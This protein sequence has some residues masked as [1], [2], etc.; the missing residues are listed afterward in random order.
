MSKW[1]IFAAVTFYFQTVSISSPA[2]AENRFIEVAVVSYKDSNVVSALQVAKQFVKDQDILPSLW[3]FN[4]TFLTPS[5]KDP[6]NILT[7]SILEGHFDLI[8]GPSLHCEENQ[9]PS[10][11]AIQDFLYFSLLNIEDSFRFPNLIKMSPL[12]RHHAEAIVSILQYCKY[13]RIAIITSEDKQ[14]LWKEIQWKAYSV[15]IDE[16]SLFPIQSETELTS[17][18]KDVKKQHLNNVVVLDTTSNH[19]TEILNIALQMNLTSTDGWL[20][21]TTDS[22]SE[23][24][25]S[26]RRTQFTNLG[27]LAVYPENCERNIIS[28]YPQYAS[29]I[30]NL[31]VNSR[32]T[33]DSLLAAAYGF[34]TVIQ[35]SNFDQATGFS[36]HEVANATISLKI[37]GMFCDLK[38]DSY[39][40]SRSFNYNILKLSEAGWF[41]MATWDNVA[42]LKLT[43]LQDQLQKKGKFHLK[44]TTIV[45][46]PFVYFSSSDKGEKKLEGFCIDLLHALSQLSGFTYEVKLVEDGHFGGYNESSQSWNGMIGEL[47]RKVADIA[48]ASITVTQPRATAVDFLPSFMTIDLKFV[49]HSSTKYKEEKYSAYAFLE[50]FE[51]NLYYAIILCVVMLAAFICV[52]SKIS[53]Y[54]IRGNFFHSQRADEWSAM[55]AQNLPSELKRQQNA[56]RL[57][58]EKTDAERGMGFNNALYFVWAALFWQTPE[59]VP[60]SL[61]A[62]VITV[63]WYLAAVVFVASYTANMVAV[64]SRHSDTI[65]SAQDLLLQND[66]LFGTVESSAVETQLKSSGI[67]IAQKIYSFMT[68]GNVKGRN[69][70]V[71][72]VDTGLE[73]VRK[74]KYALFWDSLSLDYAAVNSNCELVSTKVGFGEIKYGI[75]VTKNSPHYHLL[76]D[77]L[78]V[79]KQHGVLKSLR[80]KYF[81]ALKACDQDSYYYEDLRQL[82]FKDLAGV[83]Y[84][85]G[86]AMAIGFGILI[87]E[88]IVVSFYDVNRN[89]PLAPQSMVEAFRR[90]R[91][92]LIV[93]I[94]NNWFPLERSIEKWSK[95]SLPSQERVSD[96]VTA[97]TKGE[98]T[99]LPIDDVLRISKSSTH[100]AG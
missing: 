20:W 6:P 33:I 18:L 46:V 8:I 67:R 36:A 37:H 95:I 34:K 42:K 98:K 90:R 29:Q 9:I 91:Q 47:E 81:N 7:A 49:L 75:A 35:R 48:V 84:L 85:V 80:L 87:A 61:S 11:M 44:V 10:L 89:N 24:W 41:E 12:Q 50:P 45:E 25:L 3:N 16:V 94:R 72:N 39:E 97:Q 19:T 14:C 96:L 78:L 38:F 5:C 1:I 28:N 27:V 43:G 76:A 92:R 73:Y 69:M 17:L 32:L 71:P 21:V 70:L 52:L 13:K 86:Y 60:R 55:Q 82:A 40:R 88:W 68:G 22:N 23:S 4:I 66:V 59:R 2:Y 83:F 56:R 57:R 31:T 74:G 100:N 53:P 64:V 58:A 65:D 54:G 93:D 26:Q 79:L 63:L 77:N 62:R 51:T 15:G 99:R 30:Q